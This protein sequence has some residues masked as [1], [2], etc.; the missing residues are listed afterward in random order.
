VHFHLVEQQ[1]ISIKAGALLFIQPVIL[2]NEYPGGCILMKQRTFKK[3]K[4][5]PEYQ[6]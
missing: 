4:Q 6:H 1:G 2:L 5:M 3:C